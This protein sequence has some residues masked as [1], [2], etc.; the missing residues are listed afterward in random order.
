MGSKLL[1][2]CLK[3]I[4]L[5]SFCSNTLNDLSFWCCLTSFN[6]YTL[7]LWMD[8]KLPALYKIS[9]CN[10]WNLT[11]QTDSTWFLI[12]IEMVESTLTKTIYPQF[13][14]HYTILL[15][16]WNKKK[17]KHIV[18]FNPVCVSTTF[19]PLQFKLLIILV[20]EMLVL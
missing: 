2:N 17:I 3:F 4:L 15:E 9:I 8:S 7:S 5:C 20:I 14:S 19:V 11:Y 1:I 13:R 18:E 16:K 6:H 12:M 10:Q